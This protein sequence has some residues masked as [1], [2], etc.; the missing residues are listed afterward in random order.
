MAQSAC[1]R[2]FIIFNLL[3]KG[4]RSWNVNTLRKNV[5]ERRDRAIG[6]CHSKKTEDCYAIMQINIL[7]VTIV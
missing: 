4:N 6:Y 2:L 7:D 5:A 3:D 1:F